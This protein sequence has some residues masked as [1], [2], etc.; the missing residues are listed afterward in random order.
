MHG[1]IG[2]IQRARIV[3]RSDT[4]TFGEGEVL[5]KTWPDVDKI[6][7]LLPHRTERAIR[8]M[9]KRCGLVPDKEQHIWT[10]AQ[11]KTL[12]TMAAAAATRREI[13]AAVGLT[14]AQVANRLLYKR[15]NIAKRPPKPV[16]DPLLNSIR[17]RAFE[18]NVSAAELDLSLGNRK[19]FRRVWKGR[20]VD[21]NHIARV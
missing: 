3:R 20:D 5:R 17:R 18:L 13:A 2:S 19:I 15:I 12:R 21:V 1:N 9:A 6:K 4:W 8:Y 7:A 16:S 10:C 14:V 11:D